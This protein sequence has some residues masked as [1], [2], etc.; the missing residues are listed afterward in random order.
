MGVSLHAGASTSLC[1]S[2]IATGKPSRNQIDGDPSFLLVGAI[3]QLCLWRPS[4][5]FRVPGLE[6]D[7]SLATTVLFASCLRILPYFSAFCRAILLIC[8]VFNIGWAT[9]NP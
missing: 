9:H 6:R 4:E 1:R 5:G 7:G 8:F 2:A 3:E